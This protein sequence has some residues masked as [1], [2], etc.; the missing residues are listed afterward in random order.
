MWKCFNSFLS[1]D[2]FYY[3]KQSKDILKINHKLKVVIFGTGWAFNNYIEHYRDEH[4]VV[5]VTDWDYAK[6]GNKIKGI[7]VLNPYNLGSIDFDKILI[8]STYIKEIKEQLEQKIQISEDMTLVPYKY[9]FKSGK[10]FED[11]ATRSFALE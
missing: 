8:C 3:W 6:H 5:G 2:N 11:A 10:P 7:P 9:Q 1:I 4:D